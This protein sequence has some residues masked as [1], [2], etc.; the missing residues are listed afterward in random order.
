[1]HVWSI[2]RRAISR[3]STKIQQNTSTYNILLNISWL[4]VFV[5]TMNADCDDHWHLLARVGCPWTLKTFTWIWLS[6]TSVY[7]EHKWSYS[8]DN[9]MELYSIYVYACTCISKHFL[10]LYHWTPQ[11]TSISA[12]KCSIQVYIC[13]RLGLIWFWRVQCQLLYKW[14]SSYYI[15]NI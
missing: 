6:R 2:S 15:L 4:C 8:A 11:D 5:L 7:Q 1:M 13:Q 14:S 3:F 9:W 12:I 10:H